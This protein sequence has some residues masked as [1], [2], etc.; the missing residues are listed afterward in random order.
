MIKTPRKRNA[1]LPVVHYLKFFLKKNTNEII[2]RQWQYPYFDFDEE[3]GKCLAYQWRLIRGVCVWISWV[4]NPPSLFIAVS[5]PCS[6]S[7]LTHAHMY[8][9]PSGLGPR[10]TSVHPALDILSCILH[11]FFFG[12]GN[13]VRVGFLACNGRNSTSSQNFFFNSRNQLGYVLISIKEL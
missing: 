3:G 8:G 4:P 11:S 10:E 2:T 5:A 1:L 7:S 9:V 6:P 13:R 12:N